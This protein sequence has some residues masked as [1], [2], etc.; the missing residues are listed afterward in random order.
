MW[1]QRNF[2]LFAPPPDSPLLVGESGT[3]WSGS[4]TLVMAFKDIGKTP[5]EP[6]V[7]IHWIQITLTSRKVKSLKKVGTDL[8]RSAKEKNLNVTGLVCMLIWE[9]GLRITIR[10]TPCGK[11]SKMWD[12]LQI[13]I[14]SNSLTCTAFL[15]LLNRL[16]PSVL[17]QEWRSKSPL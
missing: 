15:R 9:Y 11:G 14:L 3:S 17:S 16:L 6:E 4:C 13:R 12:W 1:V 8:I 10:K 7:A 2:V 5:V